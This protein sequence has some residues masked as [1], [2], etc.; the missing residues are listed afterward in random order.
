MEAIPPPTIAVV[1]EIL[2]S[3]TSRCSGHTSSLPAPLLVP[4]FPSPAGLTSPSASLS[5]LHSL[6]THYMLVFLGPQGGQTQKNG[7][8]LL[9]WEAM[10]TP[11]TP[12][13]E[14][15]KE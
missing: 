11:E 4:V 2:N 6:G 5:P 3:R 8:S 14:K 9:L 12:E 1:N 7:I 13:L 10:V 15:E